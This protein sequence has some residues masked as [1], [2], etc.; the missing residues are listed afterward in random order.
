MSVLVCVSV[1]LCLWQAC[2]IVC[3]LVCVCVMRTNTNEKA[4]VSEGK[5]KRTR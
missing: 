3:G 1:C 2:V 5:R 4:F